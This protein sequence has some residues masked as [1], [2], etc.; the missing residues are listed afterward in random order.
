MEYKDYYQILGVKKDAPQD[1]I[2]RAYK[3]LARK[4]HPDVSKE[5][6]AEVK[7]KEVGEAYEVLK[8]PEKREAYDQLGANWKA[9]QSGFQPPPTGKASLILAVGVTRVVIH[10]ITVAF[11]KICSVVEEHQGG[12]ILV[13]V[14]A[15]DFNPKG[16]MFAQ[17]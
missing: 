8:D 16:K 6:D 7:F 11:L 4:F 2:K 3:K 13:A 5:S 12:S 17:K 15:A 9:G 10:M 1:E 14:H